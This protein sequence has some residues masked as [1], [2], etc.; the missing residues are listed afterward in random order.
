MHDFVS[1]VGALAILIVGG[2]LVMAQFDNRKYLADYERELRDLDGLRSADP[3][4]AQRYTEEAHALLRRGP[5]KA[6]LFK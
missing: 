6:R 2:G 4:N 5:R 1:G 3:A